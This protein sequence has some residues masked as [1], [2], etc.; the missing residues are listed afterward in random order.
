MIYPTIS[1]SL[2]DVPISTQVS[3]CPTVSLSYCFTVPQSPCLAVPRSHSLSA[4]RSHCAAITLLPSLAVPL[5]HNP[6]DPLPLPQ[7]DS[8]HHC[9]TTPLLNL[10]TASIQMTRLGLLRSASPTNKGTGKSTSFL[11]LTSKVIMK[12]E[13]AVWSSREINPGFVG[14]FPEFM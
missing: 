2:D 5:A 3:H 13:I 12:W 4:S 9:H 11:G 7:G 6:T 1:F 10:L 14:H 8:L